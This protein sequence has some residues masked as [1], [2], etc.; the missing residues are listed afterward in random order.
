MVDEVLPN[1]G[2]LELLI[3]EVVVAVVVILMVL[4]QVLVAPVAKEL[5][6]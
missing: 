3:Q 6:Y 5:L 4:G 2:Q 1:Q